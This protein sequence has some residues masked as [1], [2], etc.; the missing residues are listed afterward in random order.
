M[1]V[2][3]S[4]EG[5]PT[6]D[7][8]AL[9]PP[10]PI[11]L[12]YWGIKERKQTGERFD[13]V[14]IERGKGMKKINRTVSSHFLDSGAFSMITKAIQYA[15]E[16]GCSKWKFY[17][18]PEFFEY[19]DAYAAFVKKYS[20]AIDLY[21]NVD[22]IGH[23]DL[24]YR[25]QKYLEKEHGLTPVPVVHFPSDLKYLQRYIEDGYEVI[26]LGGLVGN[27]GSYSARCWM[28]RC[29][30][31]VCDNPERLPTTKLHGFGV[32]SYRLL[33]RYPWWS[34]DS[35]SW[36]K[37]GGYGRILVPHKR[38]GEFVFDR[39]PHMVN[40]SVISKKDRDADSHFHSM[41]EEEQAIVREWLD[42]AG[43]PLGK[44]EGDEVIEEGVI[45]RHTERRLA[46]IMFYEHLSQHLPEWPWPFVMK[47]Q[48]RGFGLV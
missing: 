20:R 2:Y 6:S 47:E 27:A 45:T 22:A 29:F 24:T 19:L 34:V 10:I 17:E 31:M 1:I 48:R 7:A 33:V 4:G 46:N 11:M 40:M 36:A 37:V 38:G 21:A 44:V 25:N 35:V 3:Y 41:A 5:G 43:V 26:G 23:A 28:D 18:T 16:H 42:I 14:Y 15:A 39:A 12:S 8:E 32:T 13:R 9:A 30:D